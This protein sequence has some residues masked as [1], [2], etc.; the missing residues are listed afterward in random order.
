LFPALTAAKTITFLNQAAY[1]WLGPLNHPFKLFYLWQQ[2]REFE[3]HCLQR[4]MASSL[5]VIHF[6]FEKKG[7]FSP[8]NVFQSL[9]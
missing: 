5:Q 8:Q 6:H 7:Q 9:A 1:S 3:L 4:H 2:E